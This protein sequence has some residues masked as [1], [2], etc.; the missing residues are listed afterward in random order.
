MR[1]RPCNSEISFLSQKSFHC[2]WQKRNSKKPSHKGSILVHVPR[3]LKALK[4]QSQLDLGAQM[5]TVVFSL[6]LHL[7]NRLMLH[8]RSDGWPQPH[9]VSHQPTNLNRG[10]L[11]RE[12]Q[13]KCSR[14]DSAWPGLS[15][16]LIPEPVTTSR[17][18][19][20]LW[21]GLDHIPSLVFHG[22]WSDSYDHRRWVL[23]RREEFY[24]RIRMRESC[25]GNKN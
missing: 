15:L 2:K 12:P 11:F 18:L 20:E 19:G 22:E 10:G 17:K 25:V 4:F 16:V 6:A 7:S 8:G 23:Q 14:G 21:P 3:S 24:Y 13:K 5:R 1:H 9:F